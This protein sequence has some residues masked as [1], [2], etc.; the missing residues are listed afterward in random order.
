M[1]FFARLFGR[2]ARSVEQAVLVHLDGAG[3]PSSVYDESDLATLDAQLR[4]TLEGGRVG[5]FDGH[6]VGG[7]GA[8]LFLYGP[9][10]EALFAAVEPTLRAY[11]LCRGARV[12]V[13]FGPP[14]ASE[15][16]VRL[17]RE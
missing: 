6:E 2:A 5:E 4:E 1:G 3:L 17:P 9:D 12:V 15:R 14:G 16:E 13:R 10:A 11:P 8:T 7:G